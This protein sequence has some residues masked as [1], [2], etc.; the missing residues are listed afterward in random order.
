MDESQLAFVVAAVAGVVAF[1]AL[2]GIVY[3]IKR[4]PFEYPYYRHSFDVS[5]KR[6]VKEDDLIDE[7]L[8]DE[9]NRNALAK[10]K[11]KIEAWKQDSEAYVE[12]AC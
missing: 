6:N 12:N 7:F 10:H 2:A 1:L 8:C 5:G 9:R 3:W 4:N 11:L